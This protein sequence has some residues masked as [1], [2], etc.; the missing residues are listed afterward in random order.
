MGCGTARIETLSHLGGQ[1]II[2]HCW[3]KFEYCCR[4]AFDIRRKCS[5]GEGSDSHTNLYAIV[6]RAWRVYDTCLL[7]WQSKT[8]SLFD[9]ASVQKTND[10]HSRQ[11]TRTHTHKT[12]KKGNF[13]KQELIY[14]HMYIYYSQPFCLHTH[15]YFTTNNNNNNRVY[16]HG[17]GVMAK[18]KKRTK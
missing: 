1:Q 4:R 6:F 8:V 7:R 2:E 3:G 17:H 5:T 16:E 11:H 14:S 10:M 13:S 12:F 15:K 18:P 9:T